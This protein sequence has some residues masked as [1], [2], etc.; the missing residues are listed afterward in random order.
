MAMERLSVDLK[1]MPPEKP[2]QTSPKG[3]SPETP[4]C[5]P[6]TGGHTSIMGR[7]VLAT[8]GLGEVVKG[9]QIAPPEGEEMTGETSVIKG[10]Q[11]STHAG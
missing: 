3:V 7:V 2:K 4:S 6:S 9:L 5:W 1:A 11:V 8:E 10:V